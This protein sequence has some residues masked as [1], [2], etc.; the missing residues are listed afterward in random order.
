MKGYVSYYNTVYYN[1]EPWH[2]A[3]LWHTCRV[4]QRLHW[5]IIQPGLQPGYMLSQEQTPPPP[6]PSSV[7]STSLDVSSAPL[8]TIIKRASCQNQNNHEIGEV[9][10]TNSLRVFSTSPKAWRESVGHFIF[11][12][13]LIQTANRLQNHQNDLVP[14]CFAWR[15]P[16][17]IQQKYNMEHWE[18]RVMLKIKS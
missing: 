9:F 15:L 4:I 2:T 8:L 12:F 5:T 13:L 17:W 16:F 3:S 7:K 14:M 1:V 18:S 11:T 6:P 10:A